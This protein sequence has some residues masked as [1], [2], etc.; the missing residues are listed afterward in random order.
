[1]DQ[2]NFSSKSRLV[3][4]LLCAIP[5]LGFIGVHRFYTGKIGTGILM[6]CTVGG[7]G[8][9]WLIDLVFII[10][11]SFRDKEGKRVFQWFEAGA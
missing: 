7:L 4:L 6:F 1:M 9:W 10:A 11:G 5:V 8:I 3:C 2:N